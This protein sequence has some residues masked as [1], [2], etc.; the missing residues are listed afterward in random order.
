MYPATKCSISRTVLLLWA[1]TQLAMLTGKPTVDVE[2]LSPG[3]ATAPSVEQPRFGRLPGRRPSPRR[4][5]PRGQGHC[6]HLSYSHTRSFRGS[7]ATG[8]VLGS[9]GSDPAAQLISEADLAHVAE[10]SED[11]DALSVRLDLTFALARADWAQAHG[12]LMNSPSYR[13]SLFKQVHMY[14]SSHRLAGR[15]LRLV[16]RLL[17]VTP[18]GV[19]RGER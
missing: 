17:C 2:A 5:G 19:P 8:G 14:R 13:C 9:K 11:D 15:L 1:Q 16:L 7:V 3:D 4:Q 18:P 6:G 10:A 12:G